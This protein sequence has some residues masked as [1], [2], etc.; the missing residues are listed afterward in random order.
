M[1][2]INTSTFTWWPYIKD[3]MC[4]SRRELFTYYFLTT[5]KVTVNDLVNSYARLY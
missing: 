1:Q 3:G 5:I 2:H 4:V